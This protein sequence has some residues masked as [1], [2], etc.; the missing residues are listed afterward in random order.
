MLMVWN[1]IMGP[2]VELVSRAKLR[3]SA[4]SAIHTDLGLANAVAATVLSHTRRMAMRRPSV[5]SIGRPRETRDCLP[6]PLDAGGRSVSEDE[7][8]MAMVISATSLNIVL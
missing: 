5:W 8:N 2:D 6:S 7:I 1:A 4:S 3:V